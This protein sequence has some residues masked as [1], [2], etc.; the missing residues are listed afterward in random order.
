VVR[1]RTVYVSRRRDDHV[2]VKQG[3]ENRIERGSENIF[4]ALNCVLVE[5]FIGRPPQILLPYTYS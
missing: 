2:S 1:N 3:R 5:S 4:G